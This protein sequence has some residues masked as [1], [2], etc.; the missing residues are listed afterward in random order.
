LG[1]G[2]ER[3]KQK[4]NI[5]GGREKQG[6]RMERKVGGLENEIGKE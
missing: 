5:G 1:V 3:G 6:S 4:E 2:D